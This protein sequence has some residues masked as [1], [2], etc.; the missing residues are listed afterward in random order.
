MP[1]AAVAD[2]VLGVADY[3]LKHAA[4]RV[5]VTELLPRPHLSPWGDS[6][7]NGS[8][9]AAA[10]NDLVRRGLL[11]EGRFA[12]HRRIRLRVA[13]CGAPFRDALDAASGPAATGAARAAFDALMPDALH[14]STL[15]YRHL[16]RCWQQSLVSWEIDSRPP[17][18]PPNFVLD[19]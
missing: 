14:P 9:A 15:G 11:E 19:L 7:A 4:G 2:G 3:L 13:D 8:A 5:L 10:T 16:F 1:P 18:K 17:G 6:F 12:R